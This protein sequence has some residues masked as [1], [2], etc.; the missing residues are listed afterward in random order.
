M[1]VPQL[2]A[3]RPYSLGEDFQLWLRRFEAF[4][5]AVKTPDDQFCNA[6]LSLLDDG[7]FRAFDLL[8]NSEAL[9]DGADY[10][11][12]TK[13]LYERF[14]PGTALQELRW[15]LSQRVQEEKESLDEFAD[16]LIHLANRGYP[17]QTAKFR[18]ELAGDRFIAGLRDDRLQEA[19]MQQEPDKLKNLD[20]ARKA[21]KRLE[22]AQLARKKMRAKAVEVR[23]VQFTELTPSTPA[24]VNAVGAGSKDDLADAVRQNTVMLQQLLT[25]FN[26]RQPTGRRPP[27]R[28]RRPP[29]GSCWRCGEEGHFQRDCPHPSPQPAGND[30]RPTNW[31][32]RR[33]QK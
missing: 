8:E 16:A 6:V 22:A 19:L 29:S 32:N 10:K 33:S 31:V 2:R 27:R 30:Q 11:A 9:V 23:R 5:K 15:H 13:A 28:P 14:S 20:E 26:N 7:A 1:A 18:M 21:A 3:P 12:L 4:A 24:D 17:D 25:Q